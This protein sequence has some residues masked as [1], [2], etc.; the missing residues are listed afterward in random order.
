MATGDEPPDAD[1]PVDSTAPTE[2]AGGD[3]GSMGSLLRE[4]AATGGGVLAPGT[5]VGG[6][7]R[8][9]RTIGAGGMGVVH[10]AR[11][12][13]LDRP[14][15]IKLGVARSAAAL[16][17]LE[18]EAAALARLSHPNVVV[19]YQVGE[20]DGRVFIAME[21]VAGGTAR[22][23]LAARPR[24]WREVVALFAAAGDGLAAAHAAGLV[25]RDFKPDNLLV[26]DDGR[27][28]VAD[29]GLARAIADVAD[30]D[31][32]GAIMGTPAYMPP[33][34]LAG[35]DVDARADQFAFCA[36]LWEALF[37]VRP[38]DGERSRRVPRHVVDALRRGSSADRAA[39]WPA[40]APL[41]AALRHDP[42]ARRRRI[43]LVL[44]GA[45]V[46]AAVA[47][48][49]ALRAGHA[50]DPCTDGPA[51][52]APT[53]NPDRARR[54]ATAAGPAAWPTLERRIDTYAR[55]WLI[56]RR[57]ACQ[58]TRV[59]RS[60]S[61]EGLD[62]R[63]A[64]LRRA[65]ARLDAALDDLAAATP[66]AR[67]RATAVLD[68]LPDLASCADLDALPEG[69]PFSVDPAARARIDEAT[70]LVAVAQ[71]AAL[72]DGAVDA[73]G[74]AERAVAAARAGGW[75]PQIAEALAIQAELLGE[76]GRAA[77][78]AARYEE[79]IHLANASRADTIATRAM[80]DLAWTQAV[81]GKAA[82]AD[83]TLALARS[84]WERGGKRRDDATKVLG[85]A[86]AVAATA[87]RYDEAIA[88][89]RELIALHGP[90]SE[91]ALGDQFNLGTA[92][93]SAGR[94]AEAAEVLAGAVALAERE[95]GPA[96]PTVGQ[97]LGQ[98]ARAQRGLGQLDAGIA[99]AERAVAIVEAW[100][101]RD[102]FRVADPLGAL[103]VLYLDRHR[104]DDAQAVFARQL[105][106][107]DP[108]AH[109][110]DVLT[111]QNRLAI[112]QVH[113][114]QLDRAAELGAQIVR[115]VEDLRGPSAAELADA[116]LLTGY[117][118]REQGRHAD[119]LRDLRRGLAI[120]EAVLGGDHAGTIN[121]AI[122]VAKTLLAADQ[123]AEALRQLQPLLPRLAGAELG[124]EQ[125]VEG[126]LV[127]ASARWAVGDRAGARALVATAA[128]RA[129]APGDRAD[130]VAMVE[131]WRAQH[132][133]R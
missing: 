34:Q 64:C 16:A 103:G 31:D 84:M 117:V 24:T 45:T 20:H 78:S 111:V 14:V 99:T 94:Y 116:L 3:V 115:G 101:G 46:A 128:A 98:L 53:W 5:V 81:A 83:R 119:S 131:A 17:R 32:A 29:F 91:H 112:L 118:A 86:A 88:L 57:A 36:S 25:H 132:P 68:A 107:L 96:H 82:E 38:P 48:P 52:L 21:Y 23:W 55:Q 90:G 9:E 89:R 110:T 6:Q 1:A 121:L 105:A 71:T 2:Q 106:L 35:D 60:Q 97:Y 41:L 37:G 62:Q 30:A 10:L 100:Y 85:A 80:A 11:D 73:I 74:K 58:A 87:D 108:D 75:R 33:E 50:P 66:A 49:L 113:A 7:Y 27:P 28:R 54:L 44:G 70:R 13:R 72:D 114:G 124:P 26:G 67:A 8:I 104:T 127:L 120:A 15:A 79:A 63:V 18:R 77:E 92:I 39:R 130:L 69:E 59:A 51:A 4:V 95:L 61:E 43:G 102:D 42:A 47:V 126:H 12:E 109:R 129:A 133:G 125:A 122:E 65:Q 19:V 40:L 22:A 123:A 76:A 56:E 93:L